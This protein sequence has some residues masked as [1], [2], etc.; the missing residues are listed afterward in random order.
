MPRLFSVRLGRF[1]FVEV[2][3]SGLYIKLG[4]RAWWLGRKI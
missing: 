4:R 3:R 1:A 2:A